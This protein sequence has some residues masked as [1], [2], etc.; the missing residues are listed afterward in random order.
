MNQLDKTDK[1][2]DRLRK[3][4]AVFYIHSDTYVKLYN[5][6]ERLAVG[7]DILLFEGRVI[8]KQYIINKYKYKCF[9]IKICKLCNK[10]RCTYN[11]GT[12][13]GKDRQNTKQKMTATHE[14][15]KT[16]RE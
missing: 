2:C 16:V 7:K 11:M 9:G 14:T 3:M 10:T 12:Y 15:V 5:L 8:F 1:N 13:L 4:K 6:A